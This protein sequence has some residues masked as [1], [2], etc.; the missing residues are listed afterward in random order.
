MK[1]CSVFTKKKDAEL[2]VEQ[3]KLAKQQQQLELAMEQKQKEFQLQQKQLEAS[4]EQQK[5]VQAQ[6]FEQQLAEEKK[7]MQATMEESLRKSIAGDFENKLQ[8]LNTHQQGAGRKIKAG[9]G[10]G[11]GIPEKGTG[12]C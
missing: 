12:N 10:K 1:R 4:F 7:Q 5:K 9:T 3:E 6:L 11:T 2:K 8:L